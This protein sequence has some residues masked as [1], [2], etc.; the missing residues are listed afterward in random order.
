MITL[1]VALAGLA[2]GA[3][4][5][6][7]YRAGM[8]ARLAAA[9]AED[10]CLTCMTCLYTVGFTAVALMWVLLRPDEDATLVWVA[11]A[12]LMDGAALGWALRAAS[13]WQ[14]E[15]SRSVGPLDSAGAPQ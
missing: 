9:R 8:D 5:G 10:A 3:L 13:A 14:P 12:G 11:A 6:W 1:Y 15:E 2:L 7:C 4:L